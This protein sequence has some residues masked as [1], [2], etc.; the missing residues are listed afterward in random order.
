MTI[1][2]A[3][4]RPTVQRADAEVHYRRMLFDTLKRSGIP[5]TGDSLNFEPLS[6]SLSISTNVRNMC[7][8]QW[9]EGEEL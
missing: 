7:V 6:G 1:R 3:I 4:H 5:L 9:D 2:V 8:F